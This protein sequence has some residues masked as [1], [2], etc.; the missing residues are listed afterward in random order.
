M[1]ASEQPTPPDF[2]EDFLQAIAKWKEQHKVR[3]D[4]TVWLLLELFR[5]HQIHWDEIR[6]RQMPSLDEFKQDIASL[7]E[8]AKLL[9]ERA[10][11]ETRTINRTTAICAT[12]AAAVGGY[13]IGKFL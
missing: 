10:V 9:R 8:A 2:D 4:D 6:H 13:L 5:I 12:F 3:D 7:T 11:K 1:S